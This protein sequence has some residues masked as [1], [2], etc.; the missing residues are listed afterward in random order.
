MGDLQM[1]KNRDKG[2][3]NRHA[4]TKTAPI[5]QNRFDYLIK[6][7][8]RKPPANLILMKFTKLSSTAVFW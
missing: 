1:S 7:L 5:F 8:P 6:H 4:N 2:A 3:Q